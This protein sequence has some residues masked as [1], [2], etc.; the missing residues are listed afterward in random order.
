MAKG[1]F[2][3]PVGRLIIEADDRGVLALD[4]DQNG[5]T[6]NDEHPYLTQVFEEL[7]AYFEG[8]L[9]YFSVPLNPQGTP[10]QQSVWAVLKG[11][12][13]GETISYSQEAQRLKHPKATRAVANAN[14]KNKIAIIIP[15]HR[16]IA[17]DGGIGGYSG[18]LWRKEYLLALEE[19]YR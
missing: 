3:S 8:K 11:I 16:V 14:G 1:I 12:G 5:E 13:Y 17:K 2:D 15:C 10:F 18:G 4:F 6:Y 7:K 9:K 19:K